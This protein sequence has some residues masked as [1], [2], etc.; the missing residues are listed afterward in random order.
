MAKFSTIEWTVHTLNRWLGCTK[1]GGLYGGC[2]N[3]YAAIL[4]LRWG[5]AKW[6]NDNPRTVVKSF[7][8]D[9][10]KFQRDAN[11][12]GEIHRVFVGSM[13]DIF[14][15]SMPVVDHTG[16]SLAITTGELRQEFFEKINEGLYPNL[17]FLFLTKRPSNIN[18]YIPEEWKQNPPDNVMFGTSPTNQKTANTLINQLVKVNGKLFLSVEPQLDWITLMPWLQHKQ[19]SWVICGGESGHGKRPFNTDWARKLKAECRATKTPFFFKQVD[20][21]QKIPADL[22]VRQ[23]YK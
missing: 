16:N 1:L 8:E 13:M 9:L 23:Y 17:M 11:K 10:N 7:Y 15:K 3:C 2:I 5:L 18:K 22:K 12:V 20:K 14:E 6:G 19:I 21:V 4:A